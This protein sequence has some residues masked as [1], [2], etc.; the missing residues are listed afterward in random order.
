[1]FFP[2][3]GHISYLPVITCLGNIQSS[4]VLF[5]VKQNMTPLFSVVKL[6]LG[7]GGICPPC[8]LAQG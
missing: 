7:L 5:I 8:I 4:L 3:N 6:S 2:Q 1:M